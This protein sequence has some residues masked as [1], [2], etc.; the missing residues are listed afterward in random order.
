[1]N[2]W[3]YIQA[4]VIIGAVILASY[5]VTRLV[6]K[7]GGGAYRRGTGI[8]QVASLPLGKDKSVVIVE[9]GETAYIL[10]MTQQHVELLDKR[11]KDELDLKKE[12][13]ELPPSF[14]SSFKDELNKRLH[15]Q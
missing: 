15:K 12:E 10:G 8:R 9:I 4:I 14:M 1:M 11:P 13:Q 6:A 7:T 5:Y 3:D 2:F